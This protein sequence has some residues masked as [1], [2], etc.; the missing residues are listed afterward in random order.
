MPSRFAS[1]PDVVD[2]MKGKFSLAVDKKTGWVTVFY[3][4]SSQRYLEAKE[5]ADLDKLTDTRVIDQRTPVKM[6][7]AR[8]NKDVLVIFPRF[9]YGGEDFLKPKYGRIKAL[10]LE[11]FGFRYPKRSVILKNCSKSFQVDSSKIRSTVSG[12]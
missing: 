11:G 8:R 12:C 4:L 10:I 9:T 2:T 5:R 6:L 3:Q 7:M 1:P